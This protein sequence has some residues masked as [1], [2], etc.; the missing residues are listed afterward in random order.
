MNTTP[1]LPNSSATDSASPPSEGRLPQ[2]APSPRRLFGVAV[3]AAILGFGITLSF[4]YADHDPKPHGVRIAIAAPPA[5]SAKALVVPPSGPVTIVTAGAEGVLQQQALTAALT[6]GS[7]SM[8]RAAKS[9]DVAPLPSGDRAGLSSFV[10]GL[11]LLIPSV[12]GG[13]GLFLLGSRPS[14]TSSTSTDITSGIR[15]SS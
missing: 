4:G 5:V 14:G 6:A 12:L 11:G 2:S 10:F 8:H 1:E 3:F 15:C 13:L 9:L 7:R